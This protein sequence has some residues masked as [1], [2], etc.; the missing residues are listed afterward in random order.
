MEK[1]NLSLARM[2]RVAALSHVPALLALVAFADEAS[3]RTTRAITARSRARGL[4]IASLSLVS[5]ISTTSDIVD[6][7]AAYAHAEA[8]TAYAEALAAHAAYAANVFKLTALA[9]KDNIAFVAF[10]P[11]VE[12]FCGV[13]LPDVGGASGSRNHDSPEFATQ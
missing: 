12:E 3:A 7:A 8:H 11:E 5:G 13:V 10:K 9:A 4:A 2:A 1:H 6:E